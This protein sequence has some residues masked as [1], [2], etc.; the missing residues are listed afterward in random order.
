MSNVEEGKM[1][2]ELEVEPQRQRGTEV[3]EETKKEGRRMSN[4]EQGISNIE[5]CRW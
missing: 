2:V 4:I 5:G 3:H 1:N